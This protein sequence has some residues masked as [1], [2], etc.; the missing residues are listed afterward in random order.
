MP[1]GD[2]GSVCSFEG[3]E[4]GFWVTGVEM[5][6]ARV[7]NDGFWKPPEVVI[8]SVVMPQILPQLIL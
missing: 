7:D 8:L 4:I 3:S 6:R 1:N 2:T 5:G